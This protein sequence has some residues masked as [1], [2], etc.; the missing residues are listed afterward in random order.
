MPSWLVVILV[1][2]AAVGLFVLGLSITIIV[3]GHFIDS[4]ISTNKN[5][6]K[7]GIKC[8]VQET[9]EDMGL[10]DC[11]DDAAGCSGNCSACDI[12]HSADKNKK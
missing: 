8:A 6:Q 4:E 7:L 10:A 5:M 9:R 11:D 3:K 12:E 2:I 1:A